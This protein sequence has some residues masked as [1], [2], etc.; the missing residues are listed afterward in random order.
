MTLIPIRIDVDIQPFTPQPALPLP[1]EYLNL[2]INPALPA[3]KTPDQTPAYR[4][5]DIFLW[6]LHET[7][8]TPDQFATI[9]IHDLDL[10][11]NVGLVAEI[12][13]Q[14][15]SQ[16]EEYAGVALHPLFHSTDNSAAA[17]G[18][19]QSAIQGTT[20]GSGSASSTPAP[21]PLT[22]GLVN[23]NSTPTRTLHTNNN[24]IKATASPVPPPADGEP[25]PDDTYRCVVSLNIN[26]QN[27]LYPD[28]FEWS[29]LHP[30][31]YAERFAKQTCADMGLHGE[32]VPAMAHAI[33]EA[34]LRLKKEACEAGGLVSKGYGAEVDNMSLNEAGA[35]WRY[36]HE[37]LGVEWEPKL[38]FLSKEQI[39]K[40]EGDSERQL[41]R[42]RRE[43]ARFSST[44][45]MAGGTPSQSV[46]DEEQALGR[47]E[48]AK[49]KRRFR[50]ASPQGR[51]TPEVGAA[52]YGGGGVG[53]L[54]DWERQSWRCSHCLV[55]GSAVW[56]VRDGPRGPRV[57]F[58]PSHAYNGIVV[59]AT[60]TNKYH[61]LSATTA[62]WP[63][64]VTNVFH[65]GPRIF[66][67][68]IC[69]SD[70]NKRILS[71]FYFA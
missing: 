32:W 22:N 35:G 38:E 1:P 29:L 13:K 51:G 3:Y 27:K 30:P 37:T 68:Q 55:F 10:P 6:N 16:L 19:A 48:R 61:S 41:R 7:L 39:E 71:T 9:L 31:G 23:G 43:T 12:S 66:I 25:E 56:G 58:F 57:C 54:N 47:G 18:T 70:A 34:V 44:A 53:L 26:L 45:N 50:S 36:D 2:G 5:K 69:R 24:E 17:N 21:T 40:K 46:P 8:I 33:Y 4:L 62:A 14:I 49:K 63:L 59:C 15:R 20:N 11:S 64:S 52:G 42:L 60:S 28:K 67:L 65:R